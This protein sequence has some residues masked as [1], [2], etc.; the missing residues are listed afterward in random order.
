MSG[1]TSPKKTQLKLERSPN[2]QVL[3]E[4]QVLGLTIAGSEYFKI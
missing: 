2:K 1:R 3:G 4:P